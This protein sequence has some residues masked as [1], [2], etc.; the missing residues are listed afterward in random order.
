MFI[1]L[2]E[3]SDAGKLVSLIAEVEQSNFML[4]GPGERKITVEQQEKHIEVMKRQET[5]A[6][7][8]AEEEARLL[9][10][11]FAIG[12]NPARTKHSVYVVIGIAEQAREKGVGTKLFTALEKWAIEQEIHRLELTVMTHNEAG[13]ALYKKMGFEIEGTKRHSLWID[14]KYID[15]YYIAKLL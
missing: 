7:F 13:I 10:Y 14:G 9:G 11:L 2:A 8:I 4:F 15:E 6:I 3:P 5:S 12:K 1:R